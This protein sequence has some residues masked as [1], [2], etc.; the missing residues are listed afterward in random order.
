M[1]L[2]GGIRAPGLASDFPQTSSASPKEGF[3]EG[4]EVSSL[5]EWD[6]WKAEGGHNLGTRESSQPLPVAPT[7]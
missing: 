4:V 1:G 7:K 5:S 2:A 6:T 3:E